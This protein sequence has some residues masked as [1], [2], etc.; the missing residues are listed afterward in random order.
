VFISVIEAG[1]EKYIRQELPLAD[2]VGDVSFDAPT[3]NWSAQL[4][5]VTVNLFLYD[6]SRSSNPVRSMI[7]R[8]DDNGTRLRRTA[9]PMVELSYLVSAWAGSVKDEHMLLGDLVSRLM[10]VDSLPAEM[11]TQELSSS[12]ALSFGGDNLN[13]NREIWSGLGGQLKASFTLHVDVAADTF[14]WAEEAPAVERVEAL[15]APVPS[16]AEAEGT[17]TRAIDRS[18]FR[19]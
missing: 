7:R 13:K 6:V 10:G 12:V 4:S 11:L 17:G 15:A 3:K 16:E 2:E 8:A 18:P 14:D 1:L 9:Q 19:R 5:R